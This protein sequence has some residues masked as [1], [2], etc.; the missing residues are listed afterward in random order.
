MPWK[1][2]TPKYKEDLQAGE[3]TGYEAEEPQQ[4]FCSRDHIGSDL[5]KSFSVLGQKKIRQV[6][7]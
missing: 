2:W 5:K 6:I 4:R 7:G 3:W 1:H